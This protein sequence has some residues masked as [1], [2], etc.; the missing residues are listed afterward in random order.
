M[1]VKSLFINSFFITVITY[2]D[3]TLC[4]T[5]ALLLLFSNIIN[6]VQ[7]PV[8]TFTVKR[9][10]HVTKFPIFQLF[11]VVITIAIVWLFCF[12]LTEADTFPT[13]ST[14]PGFRARTDSKVD[15]LYQSSWF[16]FPLPRN[17][18]AFLIFDISLVFSVCFYIITFKKSL[19]SL[20]F[21]HLVSLPIEFFPFSSIRHADIQC[22]RIYGNAG[23][24][25]IVHL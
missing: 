24:H 10:C 9:K 20:A 23:C 5:L 16:K 21:L 25:N 13:N 8:P 3:F 17:Y 14:E 2:L 12:V 7:L 1:H 15:I 22:R 18:F 11:P 4:R 19:V 6:N